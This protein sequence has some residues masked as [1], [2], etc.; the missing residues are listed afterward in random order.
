MI[1]KSIQ[2][3]VIPST[4]LNFLSSQLTTFPTFFNMAFCCCSF[5]QL[6]PAL[7]NP[8]D[9]STPGFLV[10]HYL[11][12]LK[13]KKKRLFVFNSKISSW[14]IGE[15]QNTKYRKDSFESL[16]TFR[17]SKH[18]LYLPPFPCL[19]CACRSVSGVSVYQW[20]VCLSMTC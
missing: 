6:C 12:E 8:L 19:P 1:Q 3:N 5:T 17:L 2:C 7:W 9:Y 16:L 18:E 10:L 20:C 11:K 14:K 4:Q 15:I 13:K